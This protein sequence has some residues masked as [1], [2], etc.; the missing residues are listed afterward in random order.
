MHGH[1]WHFLRLFVR[2]L[3]DLFLRLAL[4]LQPRALLRRAAARAQPPVWPRPLLDRERPS[5]NTSTPLYPGW[6]RPPRRGN[7]R[8]KSAFLI[9][10]RYRYRY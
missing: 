9:C 5:F 7:R 2:L 1:E 10:Y 6:E 4:L 3:F 8:R